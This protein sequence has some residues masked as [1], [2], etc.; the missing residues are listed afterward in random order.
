MFSVS[1]AFVDMYMADADDK[2]IKT[3][4][5]LL[6]HLD[7]GDV[8]FDSVSRAV[9]LSE[10]DI[11]LAI[12]YWNDRG[13][14][15]FTDEEG[16]TSVEFAPLTY[17]VLPD[18]SGAADTHIKERDKSLSQPPKYLV[19]D[20]NSALKNDKDVQDMFL[21]AEQL[22]GTSLSHNDMKILYS[23]HDWLKFPTEVILLL[24]EH[25]TSIKKADFRY[26]EKVAMT[27][28]DNGIDTF[29]KANVYIKSQ[30]KLAR[31]Q[32]KVKRILQISDREFTE[33]EL[34]FVRSW[35]E[36]YKYTEAN[37]KEAYE[38]T[39][40]N[41][42]KMTF[43][44]MDAVLKNLGKDSETKTPTKKRTGFNNYTGDENISE[45]E[46]K[47]IARRMGR[48]EQSN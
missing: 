36:E 26:I 37:I 1:A 46:K 44:Y 38:I 5:Y 30:S 33:K 10:E 25:C 48:A 47:M 20:I 21:L 18:I 3:Y 13:V 23:F 4:L 22:M 15:R 24:L 17:D 39:I 35:L 2:A 31:M 34:K 27:W 42:G 29:E 41:T 28:A 19:K 14:I 16:A 6:C 43:K 12:R 32:K 45:F 8:S 11:E 40:M 9:N 7:D